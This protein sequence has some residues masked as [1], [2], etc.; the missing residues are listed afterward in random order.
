MG[1]DFDISPKRRIGIISQGADQV[2]TQAHELVRMSKSS[3][4]LF[5]APNTGS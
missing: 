1:K 4:D 5:T 2:P 3:I